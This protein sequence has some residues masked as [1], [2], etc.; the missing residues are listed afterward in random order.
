MTPSI[1]ESIVAATQADLAERKARV[2]LEELRRDLED[3]DGPLGAVLYLVIAALVLI[4]VPH[5]CGRGP[6]RG[7]VPEPVRAPFL[8][9][10]P[11][12][13]RSSR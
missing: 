6:S 10:T 1:L 8:W 11:A 12:T 5:P 9:T 2:P 7:S 4:R 13:R 3:Q